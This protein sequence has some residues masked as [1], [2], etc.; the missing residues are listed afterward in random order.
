M[1]LVWVLLVSL[2]VLFDFIVVVFGTSCYQRLLLL[3]FGLVFYTGLI[4]CFIYLICV[5]DVC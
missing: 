1:F 4:V 2:L 3:R 5:F